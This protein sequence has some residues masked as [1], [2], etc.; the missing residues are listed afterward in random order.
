MLLCSNYLAEA[1]RM[2][3]LVFGDMTPNLELYEKISKLDFSDYDFILTT[4]DL[5]TSREMWKFGQK[6]TMEGAKNKL[7]NEKNYIKYH[8]QVFNNECELFKKTIEKI[9]EISKKVKIYGVLGNADLIAFTSQ[10]NLDKYIINLH[11]KIVKIGD[12]F[13]IGYEGEPLKL[14]EME[15]DKTDLIG[16]P[17]KWSSE[18]HRGFDEN[19]AFQYLS[20]LFGKLDTSKIIFITHS[21]PYGILDKVNPEVIDWAIKSYGNMSKNGN[22]GSTAFQKIDEKFKPLLHIFSHVHET[23]GIKRNQTTYVNIGSTAEDRKIAEIEIFNDVNIKFIK[24]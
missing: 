3:F 5:A 19:K 13:F 17:I 6:R 16:L 10:T 20:K 15:Q 2:K 9:G 24:I 18:N 21:P 12:Y 14:F 23:S 4:G 7:T 8:N 1:N 11:N 22:I